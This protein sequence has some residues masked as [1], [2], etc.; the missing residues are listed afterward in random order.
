MP[1][2]HS[3]RDGTTPATQCVFTLQQ[4]EMKLQNHVR[5]HSTTAQLQCALIKHVCMC[6]EKGLEEYTRTGVTGEL[7]EGLGGPR[8]LI[9]ESLR[10]N[11]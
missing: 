7:E 10:M 2:A 6:V 4:S 5:Y 3:D 1:C 11:I 8:T 9:F